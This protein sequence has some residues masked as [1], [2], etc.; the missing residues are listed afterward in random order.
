MEIE[1]NVQDRAMILFASAVLLS[2]KPRA[3]MCGLA[4][5][6]LDC[7]GECCAFER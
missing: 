5:W 3:A 4:L 6:F 2:G 7:V 1:S